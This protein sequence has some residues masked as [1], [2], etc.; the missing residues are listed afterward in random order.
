MHNYIYEHMTKMFIFLK[1]QQLLKHI[2]S[3]LWGLVQCLWVSP[4]YMVSA[5]QLFKD[6]YKVKSLESLHKYITFQ[7]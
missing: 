3:S 7:S 1:F 2:F 5:L 6:V 4:L